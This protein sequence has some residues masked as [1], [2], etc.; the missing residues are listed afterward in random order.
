MKCSICG[1][2]LLWDPISETRFDSGGMVTVE[3]FGKTVEI[4]AAELF[5]K[6]PTPHE[7]SLAKI[8]EFLRTHQFTAA[9]IKDARTWGLRHLRLT[10]AS[11]RVHGLSNVLKLDSDLDIYPDKVSD[12]LKRL[13]VNLGYVVGDGPT[14]IHDPHGVSV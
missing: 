2:R 9:D 10:A 1:G 12:A 11:N 3:R 6:H 8:D 4:C 5:W 7:E 13:P 14:T